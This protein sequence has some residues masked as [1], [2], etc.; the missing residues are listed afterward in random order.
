MVHW[1]G[2]SASVRWEGCPWVQTE[3]LQICWGSCETSTQ[4]QP[5]RRRG[6]KHSTGH[7]RGVVWIAATLVQQS[8]LSVALVNSSAAFSQL[9]SLQ[10]RRSPWRQKGDDSYNRRGITRQCRSPAGHRGLRERWD[11]P[12]RHRCESAGPIIYLT[13]TEWSESQPAHKALSES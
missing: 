13:N 7:Q 10:T 11:H 8:S 9:S 1:T 6:D 3:W 4:Y 5:A 2:G 12:L